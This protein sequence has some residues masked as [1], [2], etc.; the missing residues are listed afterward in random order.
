PARGAGAGYRARADGVSARRAA[1]R[2]RYRIPRRDVRRITRPAR[3]P[4]SDYRLRYTRPARGDGDGRHDRAHEPRRDRA[5]RNAA[6][7][8]R[9]AGVDVRRGLHWVAADELSSLSR[10]RGAR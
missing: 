3:P 7:H 4:E 2:A 9:S 10:E 5:T 1:W 6:G 8:L